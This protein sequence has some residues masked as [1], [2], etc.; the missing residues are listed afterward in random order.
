MDRKF[1]ST[2]SISLLSEG[3]RF[4]SAH[5]SGLVR[6]WS[7]TSGQELKRWKPHDGPAIASTDVIPLHNDRWLL[8]RGDDKSI[9]LWDGQ[10]F[11]KLD[12]ATTEMLATGFGG[13][14]PDGRTLVTG[15]G[16]RLT[17]QSEYDGYHDLHVWRLPTP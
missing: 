6:I 8:T 1:N 10:S 4:A 12:E 5:S 15:V 2:R 3:D 16:S 17:T 7:L 9:H 11:E 14:S 13:V